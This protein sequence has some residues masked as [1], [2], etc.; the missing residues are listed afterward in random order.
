[1]VFW[2]GCF[3]CFLQVFHMHWALSIQ[4]SVTFLLKH[5]FLLLLHHYIALKPS[6]FTEDLF[7]HLVVSMPMPLCFNVLQ[8][9]A[10]GSVFFHSLLHHCVLHCQGSLLTLSLLPMLALLSV[11]PPHQSKCWVFLIF[12]PVHKK[13]LETALLTANHVK[14]LFSLTCLV[15]ILRSRAP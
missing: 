5:Y 8:F 6:F 15:L 7:C 2:C 11:L 12:S 14:P 9:N 10:I 1:M 3:E 4:M 13:C